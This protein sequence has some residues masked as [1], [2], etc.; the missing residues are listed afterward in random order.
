MSDSYKFCIAGTRRLQRF[1]RQ[2]TRVSR[3]EQA[4]CGCGSRVPQPTTV[5]CY[6]TA[7]FTCGQHSRDVSKQ[8]WTPHSSHNRPLQA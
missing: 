4:R 5:A 3:W 7:S 6:D 8:S 2:F 1:K